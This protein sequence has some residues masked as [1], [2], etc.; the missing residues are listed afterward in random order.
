MLKKLFN[1]K[2]ALGLAGL[3][4]AV[5]AEPSFAASSG[6]GAV[7]GNVKGQFGDIADMIGGASYIMGAGFGIRGALKLKEH[8]ENP[9]Q[10]KLSQPL[11]NLIVAG[12]LLALP[13]VMSTGSGTIFGD[14]A[15]KTSISGGL[16]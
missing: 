5:V 13:S 15:S 12:A 14:G 16:R 6:L 11:T 2:V 3:S 9:Q 1:T 4:L 10:I 7:A 8:N